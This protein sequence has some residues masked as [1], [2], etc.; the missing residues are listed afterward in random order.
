MFTWIVLFPVNSTI[1]ELILDLVIGP[2]TI[3]TINQ[4]FSTITLR[5]HSMLFPLSVDSLC[6]FS[7]VC[8]SPVFLCHLCVGQTCHLGLQASRLQT[9][10][11]VT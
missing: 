10:E 4:P 3:L 9:D 6:S 2:N 1:Q 5:K 8:V 11:S 7:L